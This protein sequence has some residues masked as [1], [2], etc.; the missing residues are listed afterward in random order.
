G[1]PIVGS[2]VLVTTQVAAVAG[3]A[4]SKKR[5]LHEITANRWWRMTFPLRW[6]MVLKGAQPPFLVSSV[7]RRKTGSFLFR[8]RCRLPLTG[9]RYGTP[10][11]KPS[12]KI[13]SAG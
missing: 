11:S 5:R 1:F 10:A 12:K 6:S 13:V 3:V 2:V 9:A 7:D 4:I 8:H